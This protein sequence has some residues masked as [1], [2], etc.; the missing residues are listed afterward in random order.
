MEEKKKELKFAETV[1]KT[2]K[3]LFIIFFG[4]LPWF[5]AVGLGFGNDAYKLDDY[6]TVFPL[7][8]IVF[9]PILIAHILG[10]NAWFVFYICSIPPLIILM[11]FL[12]NN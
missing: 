2:A 9:S 10:F 1:S 11:V 3:I 6:M 4:V 8:C 7:L 5:I 12:V